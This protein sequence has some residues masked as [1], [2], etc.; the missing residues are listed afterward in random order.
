MTKV[1]V[2]GGAGYIGGAVT[3]ALLAGHIQFTVYDNLLYEPHYLKPVDFVYGDVRNTKLLKQ[4]LSNYTHVV[5]LAAIVG[6][7]ACAVVPKLTT[8]VNTEAVLWLVNNFAG[9]IIYTSTCS[10]YGEHNEEVNEEGKLNPL[11]LYAKTKSEAEGYLLSW[12]NSLVF[13]L[14]TSFGLSD[15][16]SRPRMDLVVN[17]M[18]VAALTKG[19]I[20]LYGGEQWRPLIHVKDIASAIVENLDRPVTG[21]Y[22]IAS[23]NLQIKTLAA[24]CAGITKCNVICSELESKDTRNYRV[25]TKKALRDRIF[26]PYTVYSIA[27]GIREFVNLIHS[28]RIKD[29]ENNLYFNVRHMSELKEN[30]I[31]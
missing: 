19:E 17:Q 3:D 5:W 28:S 20:M 16:Y 9:R 11:S 27:D 4:I 30:G 18:S 31:S 21:T 14:G 1:L 10:V 24:T 7:G 26:N 22:N 13:R 25:S 8:E 2:V 15:S 23:V 6:D 12:P 29:T